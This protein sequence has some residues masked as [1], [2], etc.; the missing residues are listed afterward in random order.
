[1]AATSERLVLREFMDS[2]EGWGRDQGRVVYNRLLHFVEDN[3]GTVLF[4]VSLDGVRRVDISFASETIVEI[5]RRFR[6]AKGFYFVDL[7]NRDMLENWEAA[8]E[9]KGQPIM[10]WK[11]RVGRVIGLQPSQGTVEALQFAL[12]RQ[13]ARASEFVKAVPQVSIANASTKFKQL[14]EQ[15]FLLR[16]ENI[17]ESGGMEYDYIRIGA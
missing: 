13:S 5:A 2:E 6:G 9:K 3:A 17:A 12:K 16:R 15:G 4:P 11:G 1:M 10:V 8:A 14:W 7:E